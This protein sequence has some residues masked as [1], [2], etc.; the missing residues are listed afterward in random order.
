MTRGFHF[1]GIGG[2]GMS[3]LARILLEKGQK[4][5]G[6]DLV[7]SP[8]TESLQTLG[9]DIAI[10]HHPENIS[11]GKTVVFSSGI[12]ES[13]PEYQAAIE[14]KCEMVHRSECLLRL[15]EHKKVLAVGGTH[16]KTT[17]ASMLAWV[18]EVCQFKPS[19][20]IGGIVKNFEVNGRSGSGPYFVV[21]ADESDG[22]LVKYRP[23]GSIV[24][25]IGLDHMDHFKTVDSLKECFRTFFSHVSQSEYCFWSGADALIREIAP[26][27][28]SYGFERNCDLKGS[29]FIQKGWKSFVDIEF[30]GRKFAEIEIPLAGKHN[31]LNAMAVFGLALKLGARESRIRQAIK[32]FQGV[33]RRCEFKWE[34]NGITFLDDYAHHPTEIQ[35]TLEAIRNANPNR[36]LIAVFQPHRYSRTRDCMNSFS[37]TFNSADQVI[38]TDIYSAG[39]EPIPGIESHQI[40]KILEQS[41]L[42]SCCYFPRDQLPFQLNHILEK[43][44]VV[45][46][47]GAGNI[48]SVSKETLEGLVEEG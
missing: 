16:G 1:I 5:S 34:K 46:T 22:T 48:T 17:T 13:N 23:L 39:E 30:Q 27:G 35:A 37:Q 20:A 43:G 7:R 3:S 2:I 11:P 31:V 21:E 45:V 28:Y 41:S 44:D 4:V 18:L 10:G 38:V 14:L 19:F 42:I 15:A 33:K 36:R 6:S 12:K 40:L 32:A 26:K 29:H 9:A 24:T 47:L 8:L 25:N